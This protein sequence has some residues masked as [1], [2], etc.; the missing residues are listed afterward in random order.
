MNYYRLSIFYKRDVFFSFDGNSDKKELEN[1]VFFGKSNP[2]KYTVDKIDKYLLNYDI[3]PTIGAPLVSTKFKAEFERLLGHDCEFLPATIVSSE[4]GII[5]NSFYVL[6]LLKVIECIDY[7]RSEVRPLI[8]NVPNSPI[9]IIVLYL[10]KE[11]LQ[12]VHICRMQESKSIIIVDETFAD[13]C[14]KIGINGIGF[15]KEGNQ[16]QPDFFE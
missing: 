10:N 8:K 4:N 16:Q 9:K 1:G 12:N 7:S 14:N 3:L 15:I 6:N 2:I 13:L 11:N 5:E